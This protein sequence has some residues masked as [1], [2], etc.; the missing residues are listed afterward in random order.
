MTIS[1]EIGVEK[2]DP[3]IFQAALHAAGVPVKQ[4]VHVGDSDTADVR[5]AEAVGMTAVLLNRGEGEGV[6]VRDLRDLWTKLDAA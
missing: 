3:R 1:C 5:G 4:A 6:G 2:P